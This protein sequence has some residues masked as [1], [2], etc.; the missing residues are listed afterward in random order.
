MKPLVYYYCLDLPSD[1]E[2]SIEASLQELEKLMKLPPLNVRCPI[3]RLPE[4]IRPSI[5]GA[6]ECSEF[7]ECAIA[8]SDKLEDWCKLVSSDEPKHRY[9]PGLIVF[10]SRQHDLAQ[11]CLT[12]NP[13]ALWGGK[14]SRLAVVYELDNYCAI[15][16]ELL[17]LLGAEDCYDTDNPGPTCKHQQCIM[18]YAPTKG[19]VD[20]RLPLCSNNVNQIKKLLSIIKD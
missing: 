14:N 7:L 20:G 17:H 12:A 18:Q 9:V 11:K 3:E 6:L 2:A 5:L 10:C 19:I 1:R 8:I 15:W 13:N 4:D 16:H